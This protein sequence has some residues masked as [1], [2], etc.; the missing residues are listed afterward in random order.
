MVEAAVASV[1]LEAHLLEGLAIPLPLPIVM[2]LNGLTLLPDPLGLEKFR[3]VELRGVAHATHTEARPIGQR[4][5]IRLTSDD[6]ADADSWALQTLR[7]RARQED[8]A[9]VQ[10]LDV[11]DAAHRRRMVHF[12]RFVEEDAVL[13]LFGQADELLKLLA[14]ARVTCRVAGVGDDGHEVRLGVQGRAIVVGGVR[15]ME[16]VLL[17]ARNDGPISAYGGHDVDVG[18]PLG[19][20]DPHLHVLLQESQD[21]GNAGPASSE[22]H[23]VLGHDLGP[24]VL[25]V[26]VAD[27][28]AQ[29]RMTPRLRVEAVFP[30]DLHAARQ[31]RSAELRQGRGQWEAL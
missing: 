27:R 17:V 26:V 15:R 4:L 19:I 20:A 1:D 30:R 3:G 23:D 9:V 5:H 14:M 10:V 25:V 21:R 12:V 18:G 11:L 28:L 2:L 29:Q 24:I 6:P 22:D 7:A 31:L 8:V 13:L 16:A